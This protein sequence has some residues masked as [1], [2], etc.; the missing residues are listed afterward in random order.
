[1]NL[2]RDLVNLFWKLQPSSTS[3][4][5]AGRPF[6]V[7]LQR[8]ADRA[9]MAAGREPGLDAILA[10]YCGQPGAVLIDVGANCGQTLLKAKAIQPRVQYVGF[11]PNPTAAGYV[12]RV[13]ELNQ[14]QHCR[15]IACGLGRER[16]AAQLGTRT[17]VDPCGTIIPNFR[18]AE[19]GGVML[20]VLVE[21][22]DELLDRL[23]VERVD[24]I[25]I[26]VEGAEAAV[27]AG[28]QR[29]LRERRPAIFCEILRSH[30]PT[31]PTHDLRER[32]KREVSEQLARLGYRILSVDDDG[33]VVPASISD[34]HLNYL[35][36]PDER[37]R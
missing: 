14:F 28:L 18:G 15:L 23:G 7:P 2:R 3:I 10:R 16:G 26:D 21:V 22:G 9:L 25:K 37:T 20:D 6:R 4:Q 24:L 30:D 36:V 32:S 8:G 29:T 5:V 12:Q 27:L 34:R 17:A 13:I 11:E 1:M 35:L 31:H 19:T 33:D